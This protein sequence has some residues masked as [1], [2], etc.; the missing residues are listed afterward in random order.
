MYSL[1]IH[2]RS[3][4]AQLAAGALVLVVVVASLALLVGRPLLA[5]WLAVPTLSLLFGTTA[6]PSLRS[7][8]R[9]GDVSYGIYIY[10]FSVQ[11]TFTW[12]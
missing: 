5:L 1:G 8:G 7:A 11:Q 9:F 2:H 12:P 4:R 10:A 6:T 3:A